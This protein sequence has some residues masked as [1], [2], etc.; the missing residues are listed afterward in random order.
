LGTDLPPPVPKGEMCKTNP[1]PAAAR[2]DEAP[3]GERHGAIVSKPVAHGRLD[4]ALRDLPISPGS[5]SIRLL[6]LHPHSQ[7]QER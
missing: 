5:G 4:F 2:W 6:W 7:R 1:I 3:G